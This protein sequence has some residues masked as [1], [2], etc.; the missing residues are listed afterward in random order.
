MK[1]LDDLKIWQQVAILMSGIVAL[2]L[3]LGLSGMALQGGHE[4]PPPPEWP[5]PGL[6]HPGLPEYP[7]PGLPELP[8]PGPEPRPI[9]PGPG[10]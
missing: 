4:T 2:V 8:H 7:H 1:F 5:T 10:Y 9:E 3:I 6:P